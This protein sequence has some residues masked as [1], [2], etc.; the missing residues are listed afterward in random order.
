MQAPDEESVE[1]LIEERSQLVR[2]AARLRSVPAAGFG[3]PRSRDQ[4]SR[5][6]GNTRRPQSAAEFASAVRGS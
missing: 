3:R 4:I 2:E 6:F 1:R 5:S